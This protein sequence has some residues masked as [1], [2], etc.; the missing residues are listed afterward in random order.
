MERITIYTKPACVQCDAVLRAF[1]KAGIHN[2]TTVDLTADADAR[3]Y[4]MSL[5][6]LQAPWSSPAPT[7]TSAGSAPTASN[8]SP[9][10][11]PDHWP[12]ATRRPSCTT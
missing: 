10:P 9:T 12:P 4:V 7:T 11:P 1:D 6:Y 3:D 2:Y 5:G 8:T